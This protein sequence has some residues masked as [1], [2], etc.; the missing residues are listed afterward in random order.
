MAAAHKRWLLVS[1][2]DIG[3]AGILPS[4]TPSNA[5][6]YY[7][8]QV[9]YTS[10]AEAFVASDPEQLQTEVNT[11]GITY[12]EDGN[13]GLVSQVLQAY[14]KWQVINLR[15]TYSRISISRI[16]EETFS[17]ET[18]QRLPSTEAMDSLLREMI[19]SGTLKA[20]FEVDEH[21]NE[22]YLAFQDDTDHVSEEEFMREIARRQQSVEDLT[23]EYKQVNQRLTMNKEY[24]KFVAREQK[25]Q[26]DEGTQPAGY[27]TSLEDEDLM[28][29]ILKA[30]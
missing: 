16:R 28:S 25:R 21:G 27:D 18:G 20:R 9:A 2:L 8:A 7:K 4:Y 30:N 12:E 13:T 17:G 14:Q 11:H 1:L 29:G 15:M 22:T 26:P 19:N 6:S 5:K 24:A 23:I 3:K 10:I